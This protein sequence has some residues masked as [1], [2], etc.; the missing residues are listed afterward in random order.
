MDAGEF[1]L[2][3]EVHVSYEITQWKL[4]VCF[5]AVWPVKPGTLRTEREAGRHCTQNAYIVKIDQTPSVPN[6]SHCSTQTSP[7]RSYSRLSTFRRTF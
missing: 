7:H 3:L 6:V 4:P 1:V 5:F 2:L